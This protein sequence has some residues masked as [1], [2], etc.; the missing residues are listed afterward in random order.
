MRPGANPLAL[1]VTPRLQGGWAQAD[2]GLCTLQAS[3]DIL[4]GVQ[5]NLCC[6]RLGKGLHLPFQ[7]QTHLPLLHCPHGLPQWALQSLAFQW[8]GQE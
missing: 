8:V 5:G 2:I 3:W 7:I 4:Q 1:L 6:Q